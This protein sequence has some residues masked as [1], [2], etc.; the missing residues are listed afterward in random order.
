MKQL[1]FILIF[2]VSLSLHGIEL[3][4]QQRSVVGSSIC[5]DGNRTTTISVAAPDPQKIYSLFLDGGFIASRYP[6]KTAESKPIDFGS[7]KDFGTYTVV[8]FIKTGIPDQPETGKKIN[9]SVSIFRE[10]KV[11]I[12]EK[13]KIKSGTPV[14][15]QPHSDVPGCTFKWT[16]KLESGKATGFHKMGEGNISDTLTLVNNDSSCV[17]YLITPYSPESMG[18]CAG[19]PKELRILIT[20]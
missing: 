8:E 10:P 1:L 12:P 9:G 13:L 5:S 18:S 17:I 14:N 6:T 2:L 20:K 7:F 11:L 4:A 16:A 15:F 19:Q 3:L